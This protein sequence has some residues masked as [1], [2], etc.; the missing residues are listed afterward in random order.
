MH[1]NTSFRKTTMRDQSISDMH[2]KAIRLQEKS[3]LNAS[4]KKQIRISHLHYLKKISQK[5]RAMTD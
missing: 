5:M 4:E 3:I 2:G 1:G